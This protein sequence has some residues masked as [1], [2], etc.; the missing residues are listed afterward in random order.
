MLLVEEKHKNERINTWWRILLE[1]CETLH[2]QLHDCRVKF[3]VQ[4]E[5]DQVMDFQTSS[6][7]FDHLA[8]PEDQINLLLAEVF[9]IFNPVVDLFLLGTFS[10][11]LLYFIHYQVQK[12]SLD[13][14][15]VVSAADNLDDG[16][17]DDDPATT[18]EEFGDMRKM[19]VK[20]FVEYGRLIKQVNSVT[21]YALRMKL[22]PRR[23]YSESSSDNALQNAVVMDK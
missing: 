21:H 17:D 22:L 10:F 18:K 13:V 16:Q 7:P 15:R 19:L 23:D 12:L 9:F 14:D 6:L 1:K 3:L 2:N 4:D 8:E 5:N 20:L 11:C